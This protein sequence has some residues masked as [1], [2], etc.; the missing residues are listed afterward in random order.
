MSKNNEIITNTKGKNEMLKSNFENEKVK[1][2][3]YDFLKESQGYSE[4]TINA[5][6]KSIYRYEEFTSFE[7]FSKFSKKKAIEFKKWLEEKQDPR[8]K[9]QIS[10]T[11]C[12]HYLRN[13]KDFF[14]WL[15]FQ[16]SYKSK[17]NITEVEFLK[18]PKEKAR[19]A[20]SSKREHYPTFEQV[21]KVI[22][23]I[24]IN[25]E[26]DL[27]D[28][29]LLCFTLLSGMRDSAIVSLPIGAF[30]EN[31]LQISQDPKLGIK[32]KFSKTINS[33]LFKF[34]D[35]MLCFV[36]GWVRYLKTEKLFGNSDPLFPRN[37]VENAED[38]KTFVS[39]SVEA[40][41]WQSVTS[42][43]DIFKQRFDHAGIEY[44]SPHTFRHLAVITAISKC[45]NGH[46]IKAVS[47]NFGHEDV[48]TTMTTYGTLSNTQVNSLISGM[49]FANSNT[50]NQAD[51]LV[52]FQEF[53]KHQG[54]GNF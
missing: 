39:N 28:R 18:L 25:N 12:Y 38:S 11:T 32:T 46:E 29:A 31:T 20:T 50:T 27:R 3:Y 30:N 10:I 13:L 47:Q 34:D 43:R 52:K 45:K 51:L 1:H 40:K 17:I 4:L 41:F 8:T 6:K 44:F 26:I 36:L 2:K 19:I 15:S 42:M 5:I 53:L 24:T 7:D 23:T 35:D 48:G 37:K 22:S 21:K 49:D 14:K 54:Q 9:K 33:V 16:P